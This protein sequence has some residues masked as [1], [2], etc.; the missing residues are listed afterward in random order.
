M[1]H[2]ILGT[3]VNYDYFKLLYF[4]AIRQRD[5][6]GVQS[7]AQYCTS[8]FADCVM[9]AWRLQFNAGFESMGAEVRG[10]VR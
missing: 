1:K 8:N 4:K 5:Y 9:L 6:V 2:G 10:T 3:R 7:Y